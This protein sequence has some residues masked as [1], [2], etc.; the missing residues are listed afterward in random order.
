MNWI[1]HTCLLLRGLA[2]PRK[3]NLHLGPMLASKLPPMGTPPT[4]PPSPRP[5]ACTC[6]SSS[7]QGRARPTRR[8]SRLSNP[9]SPPIRICRSGDAI[10]PSG[11]MPTPRGAGCA[12]N[13]EPQ[14]ENGS[15]C[16]LRRR[17]GSEQ[18]IMVKGFTL[19]HALAAFFLRGNSTYN[20]A[21]EGREQP[22]P[23]GKRQ[24]GSIWF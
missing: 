17:I 8:P 4:R 7:P 13:D 24:I 10:L 20:L 14:R 21:K 3:Q 12:L 9:P 23:S 18:L 22:P 16:T 11:G 19:F 5:G 1:E 6:N 15:R 2:I